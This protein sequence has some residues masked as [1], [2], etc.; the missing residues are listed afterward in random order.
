[1]NAPYQFNYT[2]HGDKEK[3]ALV[4]LHGFMGRAADWADIVTSFSDEYLCIAVD[5]PGHGKTVVNGGTENYKMENCAARLI[6][7]MDELKL[8]KCDLVGYS[9]GGRLALYLAVHFPERLGKVVIESASPGLKT[10][11]ERQV[12]IA[13]D[14]KLAH[15]LDANPLEQFLTQWYDQPLFAS[16]KKDRERFR[17]LYESRLDNDKVGL[18]LS[19]RMMGSGAQPSLW[20]ELYKVKVPVLLIVGEK[21]DKF[22]KIGWEMAAKCKM[23]SLCVISDA[24]HNVHFDNS[25]EYIRQVRLFLKEQR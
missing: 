18:S 21:D 9:M 14:E 17:K 3:T 12:R 25:E 13:H 22:Q 23:A 11:Q 15:S 7:F 16:L 2:Q 8:S 10:E 6:R 20:G 4:F 19:L 24:G 1:M 5:L